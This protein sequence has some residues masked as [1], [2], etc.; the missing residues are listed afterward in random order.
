[1]IKEV[2]YD[3]DWTPADQEKFE[4]RQAFYKRV[5]EG[6]VWMDNPAS[7]GMHLWEGSDILDA[8]KKAFNSAQETVCINGKIELVYKSFDHYIKINYPENSHD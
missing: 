1:M 7:P 3:E 2:E 8:I 5:M 4:K 6:R